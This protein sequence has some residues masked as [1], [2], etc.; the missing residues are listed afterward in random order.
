MGFGSA[1]LRIVVPTA[2]N[3]PVNLN[4]NIPWLTIINSTLYSFT[5][6][7]KRASGALQLK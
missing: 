5:H 2:A 7:G 1:N 4:V 3:V 6:A